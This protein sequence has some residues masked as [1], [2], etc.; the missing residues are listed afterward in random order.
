MAPSEKIYTVK[1]KPP[2]TSQE[3]VTA[4]TVEV[5]EECLIFTKSDGTL[6]AFFA[7]DCVDS[8]V[9]EISN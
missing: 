8:W 6:A 1:F 2:E 7:I 5:D 9:E 4:A 3:R